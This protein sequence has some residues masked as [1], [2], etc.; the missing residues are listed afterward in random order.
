MGEQ[1]E[2]EVP[3]TGPVGGWLAAPAGAPWGALV[4]VQ[5][6][7]GVNAHIRALV[8]GYAREGLLALAPAFFDVIETGVELGYAKA[9]SQRGRELAAA[10]G[11]ERAMAIVDAAARRLRD[12]A[13]AAAGPPGVGVVGFCWGGT[14]AY[15]A[16]TRLGLPAV[17]YYGAR[18]VP[19]LDEPLRAPMMFHFGERDASIPPA[20]ID[21][22]RKAHPD[23]GAFTYPDAGHAFN[24]DLDP[25]A[26]DA[27]SAQL[28]HHR[29]MALFRDALR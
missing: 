22:H 18:T 13:D 15:L 3:R 21:A 29:S 10:V 8:D 9:E 24:R 5:E 28:A 23:A 25:D 12:A 16:N 2:I 14:V 11:F 19:F 7:F 6:I 4:V 26:Y 1:I 20:D 17:S 27:A